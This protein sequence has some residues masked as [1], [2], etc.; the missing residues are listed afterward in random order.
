[1]RSITRNPVIAPGEVSEGMGVSVR[2]C[3]RC[4]V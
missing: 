1:V 2:L 3:C 4:G